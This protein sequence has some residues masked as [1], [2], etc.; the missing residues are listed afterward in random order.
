[1]GEGGCWLSMG[2]AKTSV[3]CQLRIRSDGVWA[4]QV[5]TPRPPPP[6]PTRKGNLKIWSGPAPSPGWL[7]GP[8][9]PISLLPTPTQPGFSLHAQASF[10][11]SRGSGSP[12]SGQEWSAPAPPYHFPQ[13]ATSEGYLQQGWGCLL[14]PPVEL[15]SG[16]GSRGSG[17]EDRSPLGTGRA[18]GAWEAAFSPE[19]SSGWGAGLPP[20]PA[21]AEAGPSRS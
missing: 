5:V 14:D 12:E 10:P 4:G 15:E 8:A 17:W 16:M 11:G 6:P 18:P 2:E 3:K 9:Q 7:L 1:M 13:R 21:A 19:P 20:S